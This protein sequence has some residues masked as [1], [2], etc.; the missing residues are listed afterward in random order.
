MKLRLFRLHSFLFIFILCCI[1]TTSTSVYAQ[2]TDRLL[3]SRS[4]T[5]D[6]N[7]ELISV[8]LQ[9]NEFPFTSELF[10]QNISNIMLSPDHTKVAVLDEDRLA[11]LSTDGSLLAN[12]EIPQGTLWFLWGWLDSNIVVVSRLIENDL[13]FY[14]GDTTSKNVEL[15]EFEALNDFFVWDEWSIISNATREFFIFSPA[16][17]YVITPTI[18]YKRNISGEL[19]PT[20]TLW[21]IAN[22]SGFILD[23]SD[24]AGNP[25]WSPT[26]MNFVFAVYSPT[27]TTAYLYSVDLS[28]KTFIACRGS[29]QGV[30]F[31]WANPNK[32]LVSS[33]TEYLQTQ[34]ITINTDKLSQT[35]LNI[36]FGTFISS[37]DWSPDGN[38]IA[39]L[40]SHRPPSNEPTVFSI[41]NMD[42]EAV[43]LSKEMQLDDELIG[44]IVLE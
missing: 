8:D 39:T 16:F 15:N 6:L 11:V 18:P 17:D 35:N 25:E 21:D 12:Y 10:G 30:G 32:L 34:L 27:E 22:H 19:E 38:Y 31:S 43:Q 33:L 44:W 29:C 41:I 37:P 20:L 36:N 40:E 26:G 5:S 7:R 2:N 3:V 24:G 4:R 1:S 42:T 13:V 14:K 23:N 28:Y 9:G